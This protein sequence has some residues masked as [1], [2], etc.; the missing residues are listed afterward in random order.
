MRAEAADA[1]C[2]LYGGKEP[3]Q[4]AY[5][6]REVTK[7]Y[8][9]QTVLDR[10]T[11]SLPAAGVCVISG[12]SG[13]GKTTLLMIL[14][15]LLKPDS[16][17]RS[18][19]DGKRISVLFQEDRLL[20]WL[21]VYENVAAALDRPSEKEIMRL[22]SMVSLEEA[23]DKYPHMLSG[24]M[25]RRAAIARALLFGGDIYLFDEPFKGLDDTLKSGMIDRIRKECAGKLLVVISHDAEEAEQLTKECR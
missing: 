5:E 4:P 12:R 20:P 10:V 15:G 25:K 23:A 17:I 19:F 9:G 13:I 22:L 2:F 7:C 18:G 1:I 6:L 21:T 11:L 24:G 3:Y 8:A 14:A 16:G